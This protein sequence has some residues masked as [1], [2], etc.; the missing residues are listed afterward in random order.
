M[1]IRDSLIWATRTGLRRGPLAAVLYTLLNLAPVLVMIYIYFF[2]YSLVADHYQ[3]VALPGVIA[4]VV[5]GLSHAARVRNI[6]RLPLKIASIGLVALRAGLTWQQ[7]GIYQSP[8]RLWRD[9]LARNPGCLEVWALLVRE[10]HKVDDSIL[11]YEGYRVPS[12]FLVGYG[13]DVDEKFRN[14]PDVRIVKVASD[15]VSEGPEGE[16]ES[17]A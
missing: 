13:L 7:V 2:R 15:E 5:G 16:V 6:D 3:Y 4:L 12:D 10:N 14:L 1:C 11:R 8:Q 9:T 17:A